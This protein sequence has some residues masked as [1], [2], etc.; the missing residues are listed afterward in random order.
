MNQYSHFIGI[1]ELSETNE[2]FKD[3]IN[4]EVDSRKSENFYFDEKSCKTKKNLTKLNELAICPFYHK[5][6]D[7]EDRIPHLRMIVVCK[8]KKCT[9]TPSQDNDGIYNCSP[10]K[11]LLPALKRNG[12]SN[13]VNKWIPILEYVSVACECRRVFT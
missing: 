10:V 9:R 13:G 11:V 8:C 12:C 2:I 1:I 3:F 6:E 7:R 5:I 4:D